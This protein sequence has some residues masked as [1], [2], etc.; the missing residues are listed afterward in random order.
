MFPQQRQM[1]ATLLPSCVV[2]ATLCLAGV[3]ATTQ[4]ASPASMGEAQKVHIQAP[5]AWKMNDLFRPFE[6]NLRTRESMVRFS[7]VGVIVA[8]AIIWWRK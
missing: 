8:L 5:L 3:P 2:L 7:F 6:R 1:R 4:A